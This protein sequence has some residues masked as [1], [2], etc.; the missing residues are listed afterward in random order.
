VQGVDA[1]CEFNLPDADVVPLCQ[2][3]AIFPGQI[4]ENS[5]AGFHFFIR[6][7]KR[8]QVRSRPVCAK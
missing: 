6:D 3:I 2:G 8:A 4:G 5:V 1:G 7:Q